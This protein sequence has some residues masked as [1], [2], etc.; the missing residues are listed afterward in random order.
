[1]SNEAANQHILIVDDDE[2]VRT[3]FRLALAHLPYRLSE[4]SDG[5][6]GAE[7]AIK[8]A[9]DL[10]FLDLRMPRL[11]GVGALRRIR[12]VKPDLMVYVATAFHREV[13]DALV[14]ARGD[15]LEFELL[16]K[17]LERSQII[18]LV[19]SLLPPSSDATDGADD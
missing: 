15:G 16:R 7:M 9:V 5:E 13:F 17:P 2:A 3:A 12:S 4:A 19:T 6:S 11:D 1:M 8:E 18:E 14:E 10:V